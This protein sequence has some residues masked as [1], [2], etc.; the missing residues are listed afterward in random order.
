MLILAQIDDR[1]GEVLGHAVGELLE[2]GACNVQVLASH[3]KKGRPGTVLLI[4]AEA[5]VEAEVAAYLATELGVWGYH[6]LESRHRHFETTLQERRVAVVCGESSRTFT[7]SCKFFRH[8]G[9][10]VRVK[11]ERDDV[12][13][14]AAFVCGSDPACSSDTVRLLLEHAIRREAESGDVRVEF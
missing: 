4:D 5:G 10:L 1:S 12:E 13:A 3:T 8:E 2:L 6:V 14:V 11:V 7:L 9:S